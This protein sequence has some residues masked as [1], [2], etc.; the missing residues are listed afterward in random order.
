[1]I[2]WGS[3]AADGGLPLWDCKTGALG[4]GFLGKIDNNVWRISPFEWL[5]GTTQI[6]YGSPT[7]LVIWDALTNTAVGHYKGAT[8]G[9]WE[10]VGGIAIHPT[11]SNWILWTSSEGIR[12]WDAQSNSDLGV[13]NSA[14]GNWSGYGIANHPTNPNYI[15]YPSL[16]GRISIWDTVLNLRVGPFGKDVDAGWAPD[17]TISGVPSRYSLPTFAL[18]IRREGPQVVLSWPAE[19]GVTYQIQSGAGLWDFRDKGAPFPATADPMEVRFAATG[20]TEF[21]RICKMD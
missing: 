12:I 14:D 13:F 20:P 6:V 17:Y 15:L 5:P 1:M 19:I 21:F 18:S 11:N 2:A 4:G 3:G 9:N 16:D 8:S 10:N 7:G